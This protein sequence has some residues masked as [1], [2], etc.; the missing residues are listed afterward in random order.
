MCWPVMTRRHF[1]KLVI[2]TLI[3]AKEVQQKRTRGLNSSKVR[4]PSFAGWCGAIAG[5]CHP[6]VCL[7][8]PGVTAAFYD[9]IGSCS[10]PAAESGGCRRWPARWRLTGHRG[11]QSL[12]GKRTC[13]LP[14]GSS[15]VLRS[16][17]V[18]IG[19]ARAAPPLYKL[20]ASAAL[21]S[22]SA[23]IRSSMVPCTTSL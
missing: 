20:S 3:I 19:C 7:E 5:S 11:G 8:R 9:A 13:H 12:Q 16:F 6:V 4:V 15:S 18:N 2:A 23:R 21:R 14:S 22:C 17:S 10:G 1:Y